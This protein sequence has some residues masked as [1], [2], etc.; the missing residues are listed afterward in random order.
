[1]EK[2]RIGLVGCGATFSTT[3]SSA[4]CTWPFSIRRESATRSSSRGGFILDMAVH[5]THMIR[6]QLGE[7]AEIYA[8]ARMVE[9]VRV[10][11]E[12]TS[13]YEF[14]R[15]RLADMDPVSRQLFPTGR[16]SGDAMV[17]AK[18][19][20][21]ELHEFAN[22]MAYR[23]IGRSGRLV[24][25]AGRG[26]PIRRV[27]VGCRR[28]VGDHGG[29]RIRNGL[30]LSG[31]DRCGSGNRLRRQYVED[32]TDRGRAAGSGLLRAVR[33]GDIQL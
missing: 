19:I 33:T 3:A 28:P 5:F 32:C 12:S 10:K 16:S 31:R 8:D 17:D 20:A 26:R 15:R 9:K 24:G 23:G 11:P 30:P 1:M 25:I 13:S 14:Y 7:I 21:Y 6:Y 18:L 4:T 22:A 2:V 29:G 27:R